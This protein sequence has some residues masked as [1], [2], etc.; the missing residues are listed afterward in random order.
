MFTFCAFPSILVRM[1]VLVVLL[2]VALFVVRPRHAR[3]GLV[4]GAGALL[5]LFVGLAV[6]SLE[7]AG[8]S[9]WASVNSGGSSGTDWMV[10][11]FVLI[12]M[13]PPLAQA[14]NLVCFII[15]LV[16]LA[17]R[18]PLESRERDTF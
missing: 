13:I 1:A 3:A 8:F 15:G 4:I 5:D 11:L 10:L 12:P 2:G 6:P 16:M 18:L 17:R 9:A 7:L 14:T